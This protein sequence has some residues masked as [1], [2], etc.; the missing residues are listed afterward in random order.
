MCPSAAQSSRAYLRGT[1]RVSLKRSQESPLAG[2]L[3]ARA[4]APSRVCSVLLV[5]S[6]ATRFTVCNAPRFFDASDRCE[7]FRGCQICNRRSTDPQKYVAFEPYSFAVTLDPGFHLLVD[8]LARNHLEAARRAGGA[9]VLAEIDAGVEKLARVD[10]ARAG[11]PSSN[12]RRD[13]V[14]SPF[15]PLSSK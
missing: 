5:A 9:A 7:Q 15:N 14:E 4:G 2:L 10:R 6:D 13:A 12:L 1:S 3:A 11:R 8:P